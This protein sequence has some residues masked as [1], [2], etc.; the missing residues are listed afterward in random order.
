MPDPASSAG[1]SNPEDKQNSSPP[2]PDPKRDAV[3]FVVQVEPGKR[4]HIVVEAA[5]EGGETVIR[6]ALTV[7]E[8]AGDAQ[9]LRRLGQWHS[10]KASTILRSAFRW[11]EQARQYW[12]AHWEMGLFAAALCIYLAT[13][14]VAL[15]DY[16][17]FFFTDEAVQTNMAA[18]FVQ[19]N[20]RS[21]DGEF[22]PTYFDN[23]NQFEMS[24]SVYLQVLPY[25][26]FGKSIWITRGVSVLLSL[27]GSAAVSLILRDIFK[28][29]FWW[30]G[31]LLLAAAPAWFYHSRTAFETVIFVSFYAIFLYYYLLYRYRS[32]KYLYTA[33]IMGGLAF[34]SYSPGQ[35][36]VVLTGL[37]LLYSDWRYHWEKRGTAIRG[38]GVLVL[39]ALPYVRFMITHPEANHAQLQILNSYWLSNQPLAE[40]LKRFGS[41]YLYGLS[42]GYWFFPNDHDLQRHIMKGYGHLLRIMLPFALLGLAVAIKHFRSSA[43]RLAVFALLASPAG[44]AIVQ[45]GITRVLVL[46]IPAMLLTAVGVDACLQWLEKRRLPHWAASTAL[47]GTLA[48]ASLSMTRDAIVNGPTWFTNDYGLG[49]MQYG[50]RQ[51][52][53][54][55]R[56][57]LSRS[58]QTHIIL[59]PSWTNGTDEVARFFFDEPFPFEMGSI[60]GHM[61]QHV[62]IAP[63]TL[64][65]MLPDEYQSAVHSRKFTNIRVVRTLPDPDGQPGFYFVTLEYAPDIDAIL[66][67]EREAR[68]ALFVGKLDIRG[69]IVTVRYS[70]LDMGTISQVFDGNMET[71]IRGLEANPL[72]VEVDFAVP[73]RLQGVDVMVGVVPT[74]LRVKAYPPGHDIPVEFEVR[75]P[76]A[77]MNRQVPV[78]FGRPLEVSQLR[79]E[80]S[81]A[82]NVEPT[83]V[84]VWEINWR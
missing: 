19:N 75:A 69:E 53:G 33:L 41:E 6:K 78:D 7:S 12:L 11:L 55:I 21:S 28:S 57:V 64:F 39:L 83:H 5:E 35:I 58:P 23:A 76:H 1:Q 45:I 46:I 73:K 8:P 72:V 67:R 61:N 10:G 3:E 79:I 30:S 27:I 26:L 52:F 14:L 2:P 9:S 62:E 84:H 40:K 25:L 15:A 82:D 24:V 4:V 43:H 42:P 50:A 68:K 71:L 56:E 13:R 51:I 66:A 22:F 60:D 59:S 31:V 47:F 34:Y 65:I 48:L 32:E 77:E 54:A 37:L 44:G 70:A 81:N 49:G 18:R 29:R 36:V 63:H 17:I 80:I 20:F 16:P 74:I 38:A